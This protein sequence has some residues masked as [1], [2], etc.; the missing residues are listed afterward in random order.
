[1]CLTTH[2][3][4]LPEKNHI[5]KEIITGTWILKREVFYFLN[6]ESFYFI[7]DQN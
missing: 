2:V 6:S 4:K 3:S 7:T 1:M 5:L